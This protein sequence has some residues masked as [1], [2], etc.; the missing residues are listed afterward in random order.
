MGDVLR[1][2]FN[3]SITNYPRTV[4]SMMQDAVPWTI[5]LLGVT[6]LQ[7]PA[8]PDDRRGSGDY[9]GRVAAPAVVID[10]LYWEDCPSHDEAYERLAAVLSEEGVTAEIRRIEVSTEERA[11]ALRFPGSP[12]IRVADRDIQPEVAEQ[13]PAGLTCRLYILEDGRPSPLPSR[14]MIRRAVRAAAAG[15]T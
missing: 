1:L 4:L 12:T 9:N 5:G 7:R 15:G 14:E 8:A 3:Y 11:A 2:D 10:F 13:S 6:T